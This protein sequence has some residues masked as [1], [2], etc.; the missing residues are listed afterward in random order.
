MSVIRER[1]LAAFA[2]I[3]CAFCFLWFAG[4]EIARAADA[5]DFDP[6]RVACEKW[7]KK[8]HPCK[9]STV[10]GCGKHG[11]AIRGFRGK[12]QKWYACRFESDIQAWNKD[13]CQAYCAR[14]K[15]NCA[16]CKDAQG[17]GTGYVKVKTFRFGNR[18]HLDYYACKKK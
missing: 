7:C 9:C 4:A 6:N 13:N 14:K 1:A 16:F 10:K 3:C 11:E 17:C 5:K 18:T 15:S 12:G 8:I 2:A